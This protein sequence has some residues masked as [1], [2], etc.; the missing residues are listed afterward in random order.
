MGF[1]TGLGVVIA[2]L[3]ALALGRLSVLDIETEAHPEIAEL[4]NP[5]GQLTEIVAM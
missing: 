5:L 2:F 4:R 1:F 3:A